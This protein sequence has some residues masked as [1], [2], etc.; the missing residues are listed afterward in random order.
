MASSNSFAHGGKDGHPF[1]VPSRVYDESKR[2]QRSDDYRLVSGDAPNR[3]WPDSVWQ[4]AAAFLYVNVAPL[5][6][7]QRLQ[8]ATAL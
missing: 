4:T 3:S 2:P 5:M 7:G 6:V 8:E 1:P